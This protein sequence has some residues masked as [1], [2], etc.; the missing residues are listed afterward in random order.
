MTYAVNICCYVTKPVLCGHC[1][2]SPTL[3]LTQCVINGRKD[4]QQGQLEARISRNGI[5]FK[6]EFRE[7]MGEPV[8]PDLCCYYHQYSSQKLICEH[9]HQGFSTLE[10]YDYLQ[11]HILLGNGL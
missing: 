10:D 4:T 6:K 9:I 5:V 7:V 1:V 8:V 2:K 3:L 11:T